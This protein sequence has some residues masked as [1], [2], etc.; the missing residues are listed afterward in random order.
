MNISCSETLFCTP[1]T[2][3][4]LLYLPRRPGLIGLIVISMMLLMNTAN[5]FLCV[6]RRGN[7]CVIGYLMCILTGARLSTGNDTCQAPNCHPHPRVSP[8]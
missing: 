7:D 5:T 8:P 2:H 4:S 1:A 3:W 6:A